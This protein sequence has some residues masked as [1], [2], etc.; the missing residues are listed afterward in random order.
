MIIGYDIGYDID[1]VYII[2]DFIDDYTHQSHV[3]GYYM[4]DDTKWE[5]P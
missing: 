5:P 4:D 1:S 3:N 2:Q